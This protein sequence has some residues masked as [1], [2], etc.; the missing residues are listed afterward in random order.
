MMMIKSNTRTT[1]P[2]SSNGAVNAVAGTIGSHKTIPA[3]P[4]TV[5]T[6]LDSRERERE[7]RDSS[8]DIR[9]AGRRQPRPAPPPTKHNNK[10]AA[11]AVAVTTAPMTTRPTDAAMRLRFGLPPKK[12][13]MKDTK[14]TTS[15]S[16]R[17]A[18]A[19][20]TVATATAHK[21]T[22]AAVAAVAHKTIPATPIL[23]LGLHEQRDDLEDIRST[24]RR[25]PRPPA[26]PRTKPNKMMVA[27]TRRP[28]DAAMRLRFGLPP[29]KEMKKKDSSSITI[30]KNNSSGDNGSMSTSTV[31]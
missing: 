19:S 26:P 8:E 25:Q 27:S 31:L 11:A 22:T 4:L 28:T 6:S 9:S 7:Q 13:M 16:S 24:D 5:T 15:S 20:A 23:S 12:E 14:T 1:S 17:S 2:S 10:M 18:T 30:A 29:K 21:D 3:T